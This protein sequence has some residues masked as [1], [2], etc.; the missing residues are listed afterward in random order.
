MRLIPR[1]ISLRLVKRLLVL[2][3]IEIMRY[4]KLGHSKPRALKKYKDE[5][6]KWIPSDGL[7]VVTLALT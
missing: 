6:L 5:G 2:C 3:N 7:S 1:E 4:V